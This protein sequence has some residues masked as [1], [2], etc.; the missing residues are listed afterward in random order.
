[1]AGYDA[2]LIS[3]GLDAQQAAVM[4]P[5]LAWDLH[6]ASGAYYRSALS[7]FLVSLLNGSSSSCSS[8]CSTTAP[9]LPAADLLS[10]LVNQLDAKLYSHYNAS[11]STAAQYSAFLNIGYAPQQQVLDQQVQ[12]GETDNSATSSSGNGHAVGL[13]VAITV[14][15][16]A[17]LAAGLYVAHRRG[18]GLRSRS[19]RGSWCPDAPAVSPNTT[20]AITDIEGSTRLWEEL[21]EVVMDCALRLHHACLR[22]VLVRHLGYESA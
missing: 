11:S 18:C 7:D 14:A 2:A 22:R 19:M 16:L 12:A 4:H 6:M 20:L 8:S 1:A 5:N 15:G 9:P 3:E 13:G 17:V 10:L 21:P